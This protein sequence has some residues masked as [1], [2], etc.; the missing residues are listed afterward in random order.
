MEKRIGT[1]LI[2]VDDK[3]SIN[4]LNGV[5][6]DHAEIIIAR[7]GLQVS[8]RALNVI[9]LVLEGSTDQIGSLTGQLGRLKSIRVKSL[10]MKE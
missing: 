9:S 1:A 4:K 2:V 10:V 5:L 7:Q 8:N 3:I 6:S